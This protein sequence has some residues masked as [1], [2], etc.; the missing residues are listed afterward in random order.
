[1]GVKDGNIEYWGTMWILMMKERIYSLQN[2]SVNRLDNAEKEKKSKL[3]TNSLP[4]L[5][6]PGVAG[7]AMHRRYTR[8]SNSVSELHSGRWSELY[9][10][11]VP[12]TDAKLAVGT[13]SWMEQEKRP[14]C[15]DIN[16]LMDYH[17]V[18]TQTEICSVASGKSRVVLPM[19]SEYDK[20]FIRF[21]E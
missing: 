4:Q 9:L 18:L 14:C 11:A 20:K 19:G 17:T 5:K 2:A 10:V 1:M 12:L 21:T 3:T 6:K 8:A 7:Q 16:V 15:I 13:G